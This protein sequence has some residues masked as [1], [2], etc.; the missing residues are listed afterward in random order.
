MEPLLKD[1]DKS[2]LHAVIKAYLFKPEPVGSETIS[3]KYI[4]DLSPA[5]I[6][7]TMAELETEG[8]LWQPHVSAGRIPTERGIRYYVD[9]IL[10]IEPIPI[11]AIK[12]ITRGL[13]ETSHEPDQ[14]MKRS[15]KIL[16]SV[17]QHIG[18][19]LSPRF[20][21]LELKQIE[22]VKLNGKLVV[23]ILVSSTGTVQNRIIEVEEEVTQEEL[24]RFNRF[25]NDTFAGLTIEEIK[26]QI[27]D[28]LEFEEQRS[29]DVLSRALALGRRVIDDLLA[30][31]E[32]YIEGQGRLLDYPEFSENNKAM[33]NALEAFEEKKI[34]IA[35]LNKVINASGIQIFIGAETELETLEG[36]TVIAASYSRG[37]IPIGTVGIIG[38][39]RLDYSKIIPMV[40]YTARTLSHTLE[41]IN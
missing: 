31:D 10:E 12:T 8:Y 32:L 35:L 27:E 15:S 16:S 36:W 40:E 18:L 19:A 6:R 9:S 26:A 17:T 41:R 13:Y 2:I 5:T 4:F 38:P 7:N 30:T 14:L 29:A 34:L 25:L 39:T 33:Q 20:R 24:D 22:F 3:K 21:N 23:A 11:P 28:E 1:R 37:S